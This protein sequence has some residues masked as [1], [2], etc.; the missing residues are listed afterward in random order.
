[1]YTL[2]TVVVDSS[3][4]RVF[5]L[6]KELGL[7]IKFD[8]KT[9]NGTLVFSQESLSLVPSFKPH[10]LIFKSNTERTESIREFIA[11]NKIRR[12]FITGNLEN[13][14]SILRESLGPLVNR[15][16]Y[17]TLFFKSEIKI[18]CHI[19]KSGT[20][21]L[22]LQNFLRTSLTAFQIY[23][24]NS[25]SLTSFN[26][27]LDDL[28][29]TRE[30]LRIYKKF[31]CIHGSL[32]INLC[33]GVDEND[34]KT[35][36]ERALK[37][38]V[39]ELDYGAV[40]GVGV[41]IH[42]GSHRNKERGIE[43]IVKNIERSLTEITKTTEKIASYL[44]IESKDFVKR[45]KIILENSAG[46]GTKLGKNLTELSLIFGK[47]DTKLRE[48]VRFCIDTAHIFGAGEYNFGNK[49]DTDEFLKEFESRI[50]LKYLE[51]FH[52][53]DSR[54]PFGSRKDRHENLCYGYIFEERE[55]ALQY[56]IN[57]AIKH[58]IPLIGETPSF[59]HDYKLINN[60]CNINY[61]TY[62]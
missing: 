59:K 17:K 38:T 56:F 1:M 20:V 40:I 57:S 4:L 7:K 33:G 53:N 3:I 37:R 9:C 58:K 13:T 23:L 19:S 14:E 2:R 52:L 61:I 54:V 18:G 34:L 46:E 31:M 12:L 60:L 25:R 55:E 8:R 27:D 15:G 16:T 35:K 39:E 6:L 48:Q 10:L 47:I 29:K 62:F 11:S 43:L 26:I 42:T 49:E 5:K 44:K 45:R 28:V 41:V 22:S 32:L 24:T 36:T 30:F 50:G 21:L 51:L